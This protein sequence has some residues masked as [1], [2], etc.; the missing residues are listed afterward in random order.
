[1]DDKELGL[2]IFTELGDIG[3]FIIISGD[4]T[5]KE[6]RMQLDKALFVKQRAVVCRGIT[7]F[8]SSD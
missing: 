1:M 3:R 5:G 7:Y 4:A 6:N 2:D 8:R